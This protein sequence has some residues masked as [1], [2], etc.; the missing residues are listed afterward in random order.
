M[1][2][3]V[4]ISGHAENELCLFK[5][6]CVRKIFGALSNLQ[7]DPSKGRPV[8]IP[9]PAKFGKMIDVWCESRHTFITIFYTEQPT[10][11]GMF[12]DVH[13]FAGNPPLE[14]YA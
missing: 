14:L 7:V 2:C 5:P 6:C 12:L 9:Y 8:C 3:S 1:N 10:D 4:R 11:S 13:E